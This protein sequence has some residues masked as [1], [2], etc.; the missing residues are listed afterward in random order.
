MYGFKEV[1][2]ELNSSFGEKSIDTSKLTFEN[3]KNSTRRCQ[4]SAKEKE[5][6]SYCSI[7]LVFF[8]AIDSYKVLLVSR[9]ANVRLHQRVPPLTF[10]TTK[11]DGVQP[12]A[13]LRYLIPTF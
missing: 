9:V 11:R 13:T 12:S 6:K 5:P 10:K 1:F 7:T 2:P 8:F 3:Q 4:S